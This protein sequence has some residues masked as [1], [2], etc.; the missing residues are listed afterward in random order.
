MEHQISIN[1]AKNVAEHLDS[2]QYDLILIGI[3]PQGEWFL[4]KEVDGYF[5]SEDRLQLILSATHGGFYHAVS[6][7]SI[8]PDIIFPVLHGTDG[9]DGSIQGL[10]RVINIPFVGTGVV[11]SA[12]CMSKLYSKRILSAAGIPVSNYIAYE[13][14]EK[15]DISFENI[16]KQLGLPFMAKASNL[17][18]SVGVHKVRSEGDFTHA[19]KD[20]FNFDDVII[21]E[22]YI[23]GR[24][25]ECSV[26]GNEQPEASLPAEIVISKNYDFYTYEA[27][28][29]DPNAVE[30][31]IPA[32]IDEETMSS[33]LEYKSA[34]FSISIISSLDLP[35]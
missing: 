15:E 1:S 17:G 13:M 27:K 8:Y 14:H 2:T 12:V 35:L 20:I 28:Y 26:M 3:S 33:Y 4:K 24:E 7:K 9:E 31:K 6:G 18:S 32:E 19:V 21:F 11:G 16:Q 34:S 23:A 30:L 5:D 10:L 22:Q 29:L 25:L